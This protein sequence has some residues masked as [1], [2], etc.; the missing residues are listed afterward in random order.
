MTIMNASGLHGTNGR[1]RK[2]NLCNFVI[3]GIAKPI[4]DGVQCGEKMLDRI[5]PGMIGHLGVLA[6][7]EIVN[8]S[9]GPHPLTVLSV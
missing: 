8:S 1:T 9:Q 3:R 7:V 2:S 6:K 4:M 5:V